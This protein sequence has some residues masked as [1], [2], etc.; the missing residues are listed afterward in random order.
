MTWCGR[1]VI[2]FG[3]LVAKRV[4]ASRKLSLYGIEGGY[5]DSYSL[6]VLPLFA[7]GLGITAP[8]SSS[9]WV[10]YWAQ[11]FTLQE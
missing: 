7:R 8:F 2:P 10:G 4:A 1:F 5:G 6:G 3:L 11:I 9:H